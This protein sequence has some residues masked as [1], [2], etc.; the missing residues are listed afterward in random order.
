MRNI[1]I[2]SSVTKKYRIFLLQNAN[3][4]TEVKN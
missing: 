1:D 2:I 3:L 4:L